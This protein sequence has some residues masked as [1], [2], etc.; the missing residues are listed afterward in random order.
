ML[1]LLAALVVGAVAAGALL[2]RPSGGWKLLDRS[3]V[4]G[5]FTWIAGVASRGSG[6][7]AVGNTSVETGGACTTATHARLWLSGDGSAWTEQTPELFADARVD[8]LVTVGDSM[9]VIG[10]SPA[11]CDEDSALNF[12]AR[13]DDGRVWTLVSGTD[14]LN[15]SYFD[16]PIAMGGAPTVLAIYQEPEPPDGSGLTETRVM[17]VVDDAW[18]QVGTVP[19]VQIYGPAAMGSTAIAVGATT[20]GEASLWRSTDAGVTWSAVDVPDYLLWSLVA[21]PHGFVA[22]GIR[23]EPGL[24]GEGPTEGVVLSSADGL[25]LDRIGQPD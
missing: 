24:S 7:A 5:A 1:A 13:S 20:D 3:D 11:S 8:K 2:S 19:G 10:Q 6:F 9:Y 22:G 14:V 23:S 4:D 12:T 15:T 21:G 17:R 25:S 18:Q 16:P